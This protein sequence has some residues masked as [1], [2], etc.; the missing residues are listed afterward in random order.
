MLSDIYG[1]FSKLR[2]R[3][4][5]P[6]VR[7][8]H[9]ASL[10]G[11]RV[12]II[13]GYSRSGETYYN[14]IYAFETET[15]TW[16]ALEATGVPPEKRCGHSASAID[17]KIWIFGGRVK[18]KKG[19]LLDDERFGV[20]YRNDL[21]C[22]DPVPNEWYRYEPSGV[23]PSPRSLHSAVVVGRKIYIF[24]GAA[25]SGTRDDSSG[26]CDLYELSIDTMSWRECETHNTPPS[27]CYGNSATYIGDN[28]ILYFGGKGYKVQN[29]IHI[30]DLNTMS[31]HQ[32]AYAGNQLA[33][34]WGHSATFHEN[35]RVV[36]YGGRDDTGYLSSIE[37]ILIPNEL[38]EL[39]PEEVAKED[40]KKKG[41]EKQRLRETMG[42]LQNTAQTLQ[43][44][45][46]Q[47]GEQM[48][49]QKRTLT[50][51]RKVLLGIKQ[52]NEMLRRKLA[53]AKQNQKLF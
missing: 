41:E 29:T 37:T 47:M 48:L 49:T 4:D 9:T 34:R 21:Y 45:I 40:V 39:K 10:V 44:I 38:I 36:L 42:N 18:V 14:N 52:E 16:T 19:G 31:W 15:L 17:G 2:V 5:V 28:K 50:E 32:F 43:D 6:E 12:Y 24:G 8:R 3:G 1:K 26:F 22:Y 25:S 46:V 13:G 51:S 23:G 53:L 7:E 27:P 33:S 11:K 35:N 20:Q 30:L